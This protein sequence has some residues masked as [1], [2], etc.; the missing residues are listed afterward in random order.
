MNLISGKGETSSRLPAISL[1]L[2]GSCPNYRDRRSQP[3]PIGKVRPGWSISGLLV[4]SHLRPNN[5]NS[6]YFPS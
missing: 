6:L 5:E 1:F 3:H 4:W 2:P